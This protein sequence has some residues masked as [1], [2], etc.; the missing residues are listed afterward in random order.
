MESISFFSDED[1]LAAGV[2]P[3]VFN[4]SNYVK[5]GGVLEGVDLFDASFFGF[6]PR[7][8]EIMDPQQRLFQP[9]LEALESSGYD[10]E[11]Y[12]GSIGVFAG[13]GMNGYL[14]QSL[15]ANPELM[16][17]VAPFQIMK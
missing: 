10:A 2:A 1:L 4:A 6:T 15:I 17:S 7:E 13:A 9:A 11:Q 12:T 8:A 14:I 5:A 16:S 3:A